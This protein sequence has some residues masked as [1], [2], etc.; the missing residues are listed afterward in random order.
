MHACL[1]YDRNRD[2]NF[3]PC[4]IIFFNKNNRSLYRDVPLV[5]Q[6]SFLSVVYEI[7]RWS[8][9]IKVRFVIIFFV[10]ILFFFICSWKLNFQKFLSNFLAT[11]TWFKYSDKSSFDLSI[12]YLLWNIQ[13]KELTLFFITFSIKIFLFL[14]CS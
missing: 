5:N 1:N 14:I 4:E 12:W 13:W 10:E 9:I 8:K 3:G 7:I 2:L 6:F 11:S